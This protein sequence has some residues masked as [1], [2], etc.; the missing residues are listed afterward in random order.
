[1]AKK[2]KFLTDEQVESFMRDGYIKLEGAFSK[3]KAEAWKQDAWIRL[4]M[5]PN[6]M[7]TW[8]REW[9]NMPVIRSEKIED[10]S[11]VAWGAMLELIGG[12]ERL[13]MDRDSWGDNFIVN[14]GTPETHNA[15]PP[16]PR[17]LDAWHCDGDSYKHFLDSPE[18]AL[19]MIPLFSKVESKGGC[20][21]I[22]PD[23]TTK[24]IEFLR[25]HPEGVGGGDGAPWKPTPGEMVKASH[26]FIECT[27]EPGDVF[28]CHPLMMH[29]KSQ[30]NTRVPRFMINPWAALNE[31]HK[32]KRDNTD[33]YSLVELKTLK[34]LGRTPEEGYDFRATTER[35]AAPSKRHGIQAEWKRQE[36]ERLARAGIVPRVISTLVS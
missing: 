3:E 6:D 24:I 20:T 25:D 10:F 4:D 7:S 23:A 13:R 32:F 1:M 16:H 36:L 11:P 26:Q 5:D 18:V 27:G 19:L 22:S 21:F 28:L 31:P 9:I 15:E 34:E 2:Y 12:I 33:D 14:L 29:T 30:N 17:D 8:N 35:K